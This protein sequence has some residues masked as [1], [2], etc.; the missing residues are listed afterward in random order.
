MTV[1]LDD[2]SVSRSF[3]QICKL[4]LEAGICAGDFA[5]FFLP[6]LIPLAEDPI[7]NVRIATSRT[8]RAI[9]THGKFVCFIRIHATMLIP[10]T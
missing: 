5:S 7:V 2:L 9:Q 8:I 3:V 1:R 10:I 6:R 4:L